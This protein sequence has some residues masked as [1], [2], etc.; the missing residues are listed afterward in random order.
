MKAHV[1]SGWAIVH[2][3]DRVVELRKDDH[4]YRKLT[5]RDGFVRCR[6]EPGMDRQ[7]IINRAIKQALRSDAELAHRLAADVIPTARGV[8]QYQD[9]LRRLAVKFATPEDQE[10]I[11]VR[12]A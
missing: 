11:G 9:K 1:G 7:M 12:R 5:G 10:V 3:T 8:R 4:A 6:A 2:L